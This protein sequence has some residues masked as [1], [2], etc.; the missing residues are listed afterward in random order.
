MGWWTGAEWWSP[1]T[2]GD[3]RKC[4]SSA[5]ALPATGGHHT[6]Q[7]PASQ[8]CR[9]MLQTTA[10][11]SHVYSK[12]CLGSPLRAAARTTRTG[13]PCSCALRRAALPRTHA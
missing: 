10:L 8:Q 7:L 12:P 11:H 6:R 3:T 13:V 9:P 4:R 2:V 5:A 1:R